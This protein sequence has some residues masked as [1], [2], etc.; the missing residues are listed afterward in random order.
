MEDSKNKIYLSAIIIFWL[1][2]ALFILNAF[3]IWFGTLSGSFMRFASIPLMVLLLILG[4]ALIVLTARSN[5]QKTLKAFF[6][7]T[8]SS[9][10]GITVFGILHNLLFAIL[11]KLFGEHFGAR[12]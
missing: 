11:I 8:G 12:V 10:I 1:I 5:F 3:G 4:I 9:A 7:L 6:I 2:F